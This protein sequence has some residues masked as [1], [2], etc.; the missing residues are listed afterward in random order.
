MYYSINLLTKEER[1]KMNDNARTS[2]WSRRHSP[3]RGDFWKFECDVMLKRS[4]MKRLK[5]EAAE[6]GVL[7]VI[8]A[9][10]PNQ[11]YFKGRPTGIPQ[12][13]KP[14]Q[15]CGNEWAPNMKTCPNCLKET[16]FW[17]K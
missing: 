12:P 2:I 11:N 7:F 5:C 17:S 9:E 16:G 15:H 10:R 8:S 4:V 1:L 14:C 3:Q 13:L 6:P